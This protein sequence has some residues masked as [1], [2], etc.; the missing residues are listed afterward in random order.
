MNYESA[1]N[2]RAT[3][4]NTQCDGCSAVYRSASKTS[5]TPIAFRLFEVVYTERIRN[6]FPINDNLQSYLAF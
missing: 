3:D 5:P 2:V 6:Y 1:F 4:C